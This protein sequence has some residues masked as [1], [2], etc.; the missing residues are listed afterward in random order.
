MRRLVLPMLT[1]L[2]CIPVQ[3]EN[4]PIK[5]SDLP[6]KSLKIIAMAYP[7]RAVK[8]VYVER[9]ASLVQY[10]VKLSD[11]VKMQFSKNGSLTECTCTDEAVPNVLIPEKIRN[12]VRTE[13]PNN[14]IRS[15]EHDS[16]LYEIVLDNGCE[17]SFNKAF[18][19]I[20]IDY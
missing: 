15:I 9:R 10:E 16:K 3:A 18:R 12:T 11:G 13:F 1:L 6:E 19:L 14:V 2:L 5:E 20:S 7:D 8:K 4:I 17:L